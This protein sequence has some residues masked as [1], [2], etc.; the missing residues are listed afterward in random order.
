MV[1]GFSVEGFKIIPGGKFIMGRAFDILIMSTL[2]VWI[3]YRPLLTRNEKRP[4][5]DLHQTTDDVNHLLFGNRAFVDDP[6]F[7]LRKH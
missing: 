7:F 1:D 2:V 5:N 4:R 6:N 3:W